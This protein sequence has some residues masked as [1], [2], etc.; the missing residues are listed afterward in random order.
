M[1]REIKFRAWDG[2]RIYYFDN[3]TYTLD[4][5]DISGWNVYPN[6]PDYKGKWTTGESSDT[7]ES[8]V[9]MQYTGLKDKNGKEIYEG[10]IVEASGCKSVLVHDFSNARRYVSSTISDIYEWQHGRSIYT[11]YW[12]DVFSQFNFKPIE[13][14][15]S[16]QT[17]ISKRDF[18]IIG[19][20]YEN[21][22][23]LTPS[24]KTI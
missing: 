12:Q 8:F 20:I 4:Y 11:V 15:W 22:E 19:N 16:I 5:N 2:D 17:D 9:L 23:L 6:Q 1:N 24:I 18:E 14:G 13:K 7:A 21:P 3:H 10:D